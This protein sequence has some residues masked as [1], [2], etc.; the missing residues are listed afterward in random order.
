MQR[1]TSEKLLKTDVTKENNP[2]GMSDS[3]ATSVV[4]RG[5][6]LHDWNTNTTGSQEVI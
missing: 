1:R 5:T 2:C 3:L 4:N 6:A